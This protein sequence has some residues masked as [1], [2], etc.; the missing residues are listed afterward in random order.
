MEIKMTKERWSA[1]G[2][3][4]IMHEWD[5]EWKL[6]NYCDIVKIKDI[7]DGFMIHRK[8]FDQGELTIEERND[9]DD[10][11]WQIL[12]RFEENCVCK[13]WNPECDPDYGFSKQ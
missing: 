9:L 13:G 7:K 11:L 2:G 8:Y 4:A 5:N 10:I 12:S 1:L 6:A 3:D